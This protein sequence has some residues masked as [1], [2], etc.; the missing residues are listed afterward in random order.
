[1][2]R[3][4]MLCLEEDYPDISYFYVFGYLVHIHNYKDHLGK[5]DAKADDGFFL[6][7]S[8]V[9]KAFKVLNI[10]R[11]EMEETY[12]VTFSED[13]KAI[14]KSSTKGDKN[15]NSLDEQPEFIIADDHLILN[16]HD[17]SKSVE[18]IGITNDQVSTIFKPVSNAEP[19][20]TIIS[21]SSEVFINPHVLQDRWPREKHIKLVNILG[22]PQV[23]VT[24]RSVIRDSKA[25]AYIG[26]VVFQ[27]DVKS[28][29]LIG[30]I[31]E[32]VY[33]HQPPRLIEAL[34]EEEWIISM[35]EELNQLERN[36]VWTLV[37]L[38]NGKTIIRTKWIYRNK[39]DE[40]RIVIK[41]KAR[42]VAQWYQANPKE[43][44]L[45]VVKRIFRSN[46]AG[47]NLDRK[48]TSGGCQILGGKL[49]CWSTKK[50]S[51]V[52]MSSVEAEYV[53]A[54]G[55]KNDRMMLESIENGPLVYPT[56]KE[57]G[58][59]QKKKY[60]ELIEQEQLQDDCD[61][62]EKN[63]V[64]QGLPPDVYAL[65][66]HGKCDAITVD[67]NAIALFRKAIG[68]SPG[69]NDEHVISRRYDVIIVADEE[70]TLIL[71]EES[72]SKMLAKQN[73][74]ISKE[75]KINISSINYSELNKLTEDF[76]KCFVLQKELSAEQAFWLQFLNPISEQPIIRTTP[77]RKEAPSELPKILIMVSEMNVVKTMFNQIEAAV[78]LCSVDKKYF[79]IQKKEIFLDNDRILERIICQ[80]VMNIVM[81]AN[82]VPVNMLPTKNKCLVNDNLESERL[83][84]ENDHLFEL[85]LS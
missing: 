17:D 21:P 70:E 11:Q 4:N 36:R 74:P 71:E 75:K 47:C 45:I 9:D 66:N 28:A 79:D 78:K 14:S 39:M 48:S 56:V 43:S 80:D 33:V 13:D 62:Q 63:I 57:N 23:R 16:E 20:P 52:A 68:S 53:A 82:F 61:V 65:F 7:Y 73:D 27:M 29:F 72:R 26:F 42:L 37:P 84:Q 24:T 6:G 58:Q 60:A 22:E 49:V 15:L 2:G 31:S 69:R 5:F 3:Q 8:S 1:M 30:K 12:H 85:L 46:Y 77:I 35:Q 55:K 64:L 34:E 41:N 38:P 32:E 83:I 44:H 81:H 10:R 19:S 40:Y 67:I 59:I 25:A 18:D 54:V 51:S 76:G 50:Q